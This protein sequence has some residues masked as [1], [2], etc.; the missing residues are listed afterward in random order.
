M[1]EFEIGDKVV[2]PRY[3]VGTL[4]AIEAQRKD[5]TSED[6]YVI[7]LV[8]GDGRLMTPVEKAEDL[9]L[10]K[11]VS[12]GK[13][14]TLAKLFAGRPKRFSDDYRE[15][16][17]NV[18]SRLREGSFVGVGRLVRDLAWRQERGLGTTGDR[19]LLRRAKELLADELAAC[20]GI[21]VDEAMAR[22]ESALEERLAIGDGQG[23]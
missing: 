2:H 13:R 12:K 15:R 6:Y 16:R 14:H 22:I 19:R 4:V 20:D 23:Q 8:R 18:T 11:V 21:K 7:R 3:G 9:G 5:G 1:T 17:R 10:H